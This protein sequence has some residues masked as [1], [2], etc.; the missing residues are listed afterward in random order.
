MSIVS[1]PLGEAKQLEKPAQ[2]WRQSYQSWGP[3]FGEVTVVVESKNDIGRVY[4]FGIQLL[5]SWC[6]SPVNIDPRERDATV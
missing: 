6:P 4:E 3:A 1:R 2:S 5:A